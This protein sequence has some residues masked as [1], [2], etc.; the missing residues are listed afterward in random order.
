MVPSHGPKPWSPSLGPKLEQV[1]DVLRDKP[2]ISV[3]TA[4]FNPDNYRGELMS[5]QADVIVVGG[6]LSG[7][8]AATEITEAGKRV[9][10]VDQEGEQSLGGQAFWSFG[11]LFLVNSPEQRRLGIKDS[12][13]L[14]MQDWL[15]TAGDRKSVV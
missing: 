1:N 13:E 5:E 8:V 12:F 2:L 15:G 4:G 10:V 9:I 11:G 7:L 3:A 6:G 14:A